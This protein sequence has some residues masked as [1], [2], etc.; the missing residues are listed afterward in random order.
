MSFNSNNTALLVVDVQR[1]LFRGPST[2]HN[3]KGLLDNIV[4][5]IDEA[6]ETRVQVVHIQHFNKALHGA[7]LASAKLH[8]RIVLRD[9]DMLL[10]KEQTS[11][12]KDTSLDEELR[13]RNIDKVIITGLVTQGCIKATCLEGKRL[14]YDVVLV[15]DGHSNY[16]QNAE[17]VISR[18][19]ESLKKENITVLNREDIHFI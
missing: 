11:A 6:H 3:E 12:F 5:L 7:G 10:Y 4:R 14:G 13:K 2:V 17:E 19:N 9:E 8:P 18:W 1:G 15:A 16:N